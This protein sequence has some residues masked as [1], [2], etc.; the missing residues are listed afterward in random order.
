MS[1][2]YVDNGR[3][4][5]GDESAG[6]AHNSDHVAIGEADDGTL[7]VL[8][9]DQ[10]CRPRGRDP[11][12]VMELEDVHYEQNGLVRVA[13]RRVA[14]D[15]LERFIKE[16][17]GS[18][19]L[20]GNDLGRR[21]R[22]PAGSYGGITVRHVDNHYRVKASGPDAKHMAAMQPR[23][24]NQWLVMYGEESLLRRQLVQV[25]M[26]IHHRVVWASVRHGEKILLVTGVVL[27]GLSF[28]APLAA[29]L[30]LAA[31]VALG[32][33]R[34]KQR[35]IVACTHRLV[36]KPH[37]LRTFESVV[38]ANYTSHAVIPKAA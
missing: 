10:S 8:L 1:D 7:W 18:T 24:P 20:I 31:A 14:R 3:I 11:G 26:P 23:K 28:V 6:I 35:A 16:L 9:H 33:F 22:I 30:A 4:V 25:L 15:S 19:V 21:T 37:I 27:A 13:N 29:P 2:P 5:S 38:A 34:W 12:I 17:T 36:V 32:L